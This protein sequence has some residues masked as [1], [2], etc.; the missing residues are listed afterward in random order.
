MAALI[1]PTIPQLKEFYP[2]AESLGTD[3]ITEFSNYVKS[4]LFVR[5]FG[6]EAASKILAGTIADSASASFIGFQNY[7]DDQ[8]IIGGVEHYFANIDNRYADY[9]GICSRIKRNIQ[10]DQIAGGMVGIYNPSI[11]QR[12]NHLTD[13]VDVTTKGNEIANKPIQIE[14]VRPDNN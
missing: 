5:M 10:D 14:I 7:L 13:N 1:T 9:I 6:F 12:L 4:H 2:V 11:T 8:D 3:K